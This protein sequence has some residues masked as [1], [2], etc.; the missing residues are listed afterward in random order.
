MAGSSAI[1]AR[2]LL[3]RH[4]STDWNA[5]GFITGWA[6]PELS[7]LGRAQAR[8][9]GDLLRRRGE[10][11]SHVVTS[12][13]AR[14]L[15]TA[16]EILRVL[17]LDLEV[18]ASWRLNE[19]QVGALQGLDREAA[20]L[21]YGRTDFRAWR[22]QPYAQPPALDEDD[23]RH[24]RH[25]PRYA[26]VDPRRL[27]ASE[28]LAQLNQRLVEGWVRDIEPLTL[29]GDTVLVV[30]HCHSLRALARFLEG[31]SSRAEEY[32]G[33]PADC[34]TYVRDERGWMFVSQES[35]SPASATDVTTT[36]KNE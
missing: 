35:S 14:A 15:D 32:F 20:I 31:S 4:A 12:R 8:A 36:L 29:G 6:N 34:V 9:T 3:V 18:R 21:L 22:R 13:S 7:P 25:D 1:A 26:D 27:P 10:V 5:G 24:P 30:G 17:D 33:T 16:L 23:L 28:S 11:P 2:V 19:R